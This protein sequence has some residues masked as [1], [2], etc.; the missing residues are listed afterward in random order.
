MTKYVEYNTTTRNQDTN[1]LSERLDTWLD[2]KLKA[3]CI[4]QKQER[5]IDIVYV[6][7]ENILEFSPNKIKEV[8]ELIDEDSES[9]HVII[10]RGW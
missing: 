10:E 4:E 7:L 5:L 3:G 2:K 1:Y 8:A 6:L 9:D